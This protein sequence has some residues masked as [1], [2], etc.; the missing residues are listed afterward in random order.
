MWEMLITISQNNPEVTLNRNMSMSSL[1]N[2]LPAEFL[3]A[4]YNL[5]RLHLSDAALCDKQTDYVPL[6]MKSHSE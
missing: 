3:S 4:I 2:I 5:R 1:S 6:C